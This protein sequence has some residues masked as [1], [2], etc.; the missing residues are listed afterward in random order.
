M[1]SKQAVLDGLEIYAN[2]VI[3]EKMPEI[4]DEA[5]LLLSKAIPGQLDDA[6][7]A[8]YA[9]QIKEQLKEKM[10]KAADKI[11]GRVG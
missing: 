5:L 11:N 1:I 2:K 3:Q 4:V 9:P 10:L 7:I 8:K 6:L